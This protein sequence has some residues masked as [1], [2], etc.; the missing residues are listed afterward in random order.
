LLALAAVAL[1]AVGFLI[2]IQ[3][4][5]VVVPQMDSYAVVNTRTFSV[6][7]YVAPCSW[8]RVAHIT[9]TPTA[10][11]VAIE[12]LPCPMLGAGS[13]ALNVREVPVQLASDLGTR[14]VEDANGRPIPLR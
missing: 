10:V 5:T 7:A 8:T 6:R 9:E 1:Y 2:W 4:S 11:L 12:T 14:T 13:D 3:N